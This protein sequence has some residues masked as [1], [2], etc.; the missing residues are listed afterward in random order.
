VT[1]E[2]LRA[3]RQAWA[4][5]H[6]DLDTCLTSVIP[7]ALAADGAGGEELE[8]LLSPEQTHDIARL[9]GITV[10]AWVRYTELLRQRGDASS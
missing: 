8:R 4:H 5:A 7:A 9:Y 3:A 10:G 6:M 1:T 2:D